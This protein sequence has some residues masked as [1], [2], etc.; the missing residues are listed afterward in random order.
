MLTAWERL[1]RILRDAF[2]PEHYHRGRGLQDFKQIG[3]SV[4]AHFTDGRS[5]QADLLVG[6]DGIRS[7]VR[8]QF[9][10]EL[11]PLYAG[12]VR[13]ARAHPRTGVSR[14][15]STAS[16]SNTCRSACRRASSSSAIRSPGPTTTCGPATAAT[17]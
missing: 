14:P 15:R 17:T 13:L 11:T 10:P 6:A 5:V 1:Y 2:P 12:Y 3:G 8:Q 7:T 4:M 16:C 9:L